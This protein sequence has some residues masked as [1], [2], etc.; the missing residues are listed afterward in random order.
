MCVSPYH[1]FAQQLAIKWKTFS[2][3]LPPVLYQFLT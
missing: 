3:D 2:H 1:F